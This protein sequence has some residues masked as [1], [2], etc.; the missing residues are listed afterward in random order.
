MTTSAAA[1]A[2]PALKL[3]TAHRA[4]ITATTRLLPALISRMPTILT[5]MDTAA[6]GP[7]LHETRRTQDSRQDERRPH[8]AP[9]RTPS[10]VMFP[11]VLQ[12]DR[13]PPGPA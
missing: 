12:E 5:S 1:L 3:L 13:W 11:A 10:P 6:G 7:V 8:E 9:L 2:A 4:D